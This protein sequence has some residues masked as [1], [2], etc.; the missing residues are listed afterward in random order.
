MVNSC[1]PIE[2]QHYYVRRSINFL[3]GQEKLMLKEHGDSAG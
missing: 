1:Y 2:Y 3:S